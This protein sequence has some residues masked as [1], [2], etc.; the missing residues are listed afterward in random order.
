M[1][2]P[3]GQFRNLPPRIRTDQGSEFTANALDRCACRNRVTLRLIQTGS[4][5]QNAYVKS[6]K[7]KFRDECLSEYRFSSLAESREIIGAWRADYNQRRP[8]SAL[9]CQTPAEYTVA[10]RVRHGA[11]T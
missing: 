3:I 4:P 8:Y 7:G 9:G 5:T 1:L 2:D 11:Q 6:L 10:W